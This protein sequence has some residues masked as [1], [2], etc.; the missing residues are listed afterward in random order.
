MKIVN[1]VQQ[2]SDEWLEFREG[3]IT[4]TKLKNI[5][6]RRKSASPKEGFYE[7]I[8]EMVQTAPISADLYEF[9]MDGR[10]FS[11]M[12]RG[13]LLEPEAVE[14]F[15]KKTKKTVINDGAVWVA[16]K[17]E[18]I[19][20]SPDGYIVDDNGKITEAVEIKCPAAKVVLR[21]LVENKYPAEYHEQALQY[22]I[23]NE[24]L[25]TL[26]FVVYTDLL[27]GLSLQIFPIHRKNVADEVAEMEAF[28]LE[29][30]KRIDEII[31]GLSK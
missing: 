8:A 18:R 23:V 6:Q 1:N 30:L 26:Y 9:R 10:V 16:D 20:V 7:L 22:F 25:Q 31:K 17:D 24:D 21:C 13:S 14:A 12:E 27:P 5:Y 28:E 29:T 4:G 19:M 15:E 3:K 2:Q 11:M